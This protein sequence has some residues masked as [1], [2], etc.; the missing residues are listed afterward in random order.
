MTVSEALVSYALACAPATLAVCIRNGVDVD[1]FAHAEPMQRTRDP[2]DLTVGFTGSMKAWHGV[3]DLLYAFGSVAAEHPGVRLV[4]AG[5]GPE[6]GT[7]RSRA[8]TLDLA[9]RIC[10]LGALP[11]DQIPGV[12]AGFDVGVAPYRPTADF[13]FCPLKVLEYL[14]AGVPT[15]FPTLGDLPLIVGDA[16]LG[17]RPGSV[18]GLSDAIGQLIDN[19]AMRAE[20]AAAARSRRHEYSWERSAERTEA[21]L[22]ATVAGRSLAVQ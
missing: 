22:A 15:V 14:G 21:L 4:I 16:G 1:V 13:Y 17:Y 19:P 18:E 10:L 11:H 3:D 20:L 12:V 9:D 2:A 8:A 5:S 6:M 7:V